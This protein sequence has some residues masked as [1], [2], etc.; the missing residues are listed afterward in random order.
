MTIDKRIIAAVGTILPTYPIGTDFSKTAPDKYIQFEFT[1][2]GG[3]YGEGK[4]HANTY[5]VTIHIFSPSYDFALYESIKTA[6]QDA[7]FSYSS[8]GDTMT[9]T[10]YPYSRH[11]YQD[12]GG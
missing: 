5:M 8:G 11:W 9:D 1:E 6:M 12:Y 7:G 10:V 3:D 4:S 2:N